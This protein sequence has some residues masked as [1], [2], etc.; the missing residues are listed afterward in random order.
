MRMCVLSP[1]SNLDNQFVTEKNLSQLSE[2][3][4]SIRGNGFVTKREGNQGTFKF[5]DWKPR[6]HAGSSDSTQSEPA[7]LQNQILRRPRE[8][9]RAEARSLPASCLRESLL[10][11][12]VWFKAGF[13]FHSGIW[14]PDSKEG[15]KVRTYLIYLKILGGKSNSCGEWREDC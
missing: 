6:L 11:S 7:T 9:N 10:F 8:V 5:S 3:H 15:L 13:S 1:N 12:S 4:N 2:F 14:I